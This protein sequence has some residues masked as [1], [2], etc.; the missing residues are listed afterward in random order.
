VVTAGTD[1]NTVSP[2]VSSLAFGSLSSYVSVAAGTYQVEFTLPGQKLAYIDTGVLNL[3]SGQIR[4]V[5]GMNT[6]SGY[7]A[8]ILADLN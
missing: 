2:T 5:A 4:T 8:A 7:T 1:I 3:S 6:S